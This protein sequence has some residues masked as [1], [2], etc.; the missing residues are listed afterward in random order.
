MAGEHTAHHVAA[1]ACNLPEDARVRISYNRDAA[2]TLTDVLL[3][4]I[5]NRLN[6]LVWGMSDKRKRGARPEPVGPSWMT[7]GRKRSLP[8]RVLPIGELMK[9]LSKPRSLTNGK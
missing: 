1:L 2:W 7:E 6:Q 3:A 8:A 4:A 9:E 5:Y